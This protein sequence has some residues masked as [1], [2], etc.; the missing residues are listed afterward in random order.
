[1]PPIFILSSP[2]SYSSLFGTML[3]EH[4]DLFGFPEM[5]LFAAETVGQLQRRSRL[6][7]IFT[8]DGIHRTISLLEFGG[9]SAE[10][11]QAAI[12]WLNNR[13]DWTTAR[14]WAHLSERVAPQTLLAKEPILTAHPNFLHRTERIC[15]NA[16]YIHLIRDP[17]DVRLSIQEAFKGVQQRFG[18]P[19][20]WF[21]KDEAVWTYCNKRIVDFLHTI[22]EDRK[23]TVRGEDLMT[24]PEALF[25]DLTARL[26]LPFHTDILDQMLHPENGPFAH[27]GPPNAPLGNDTKFLHNPVFRQ[28]STRSKTPTDGFSPSSLALATELGYKINT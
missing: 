6:Y 18:I 9:Q 15:P 27:V 25:K 12:E 8:L 1:M 5:R 21:V 10:Q 13:R 26:H 22:P 16:R 28:G 7:R 23:V 4:P 2:R 24:Q 17:R 3:G 19:L 20:H 14:L 11:V